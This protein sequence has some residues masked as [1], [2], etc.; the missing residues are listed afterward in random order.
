LT[1]T[2]N[3]EVKSKDISNKLALT[4]I[5]SFNVNGLYEGLSFKVK[6]LYNINNISHINKCKAIYFKVN[7]GN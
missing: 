6:E 1:L 2:V 5:K 7:K 4:F 3:G